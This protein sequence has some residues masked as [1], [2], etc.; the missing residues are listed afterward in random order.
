MHTSILFPE[1][2]AEACRKCHH[3]ESGLPQQ[4][5]EEA[6]ATLGLIFYAKNTLQ[7]SAEFIKMAESRGVDVARAAEVL[8]EAE[9][10]YKASKVKWHSF[11]FKEI[12]KKVDGAYQSARKAKRLVD[13]ALARDLKKNNPGRTSVEKKVFE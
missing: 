10:Q 8:K 1:N 12:L 6:H 3:P 7:W 4:I 9:Q 11:D 5:P 2:V 13:E